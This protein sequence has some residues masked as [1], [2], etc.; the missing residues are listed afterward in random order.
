MTIHTPIPEVVPKPATLDDLMKFEG[1]AE[2]ISGRI[3]PLSPTGHLPSIVAGNLFLSLKQYVRRLG[4]GFVYQDGMGFAI[5]PLASGRR[6]FSPDAS[7][8]SGPA[9]TKRMGFVEGPPDFAAE[10]RSEDGYGQDAEIE[11]ARKRADYFE[12]STLV[13]WDVDTLVG[14]VR[15]YRSSAPEQPMV[16]R[17]G[18][19]AE[20]EPA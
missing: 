20:A 16:Y 8:Y 7:Y 12:A 11:A 3:V 17:A 14:I 6:S 4:R 5:G 2:L 13:V 19:E 9:P 1:K 10:V 15:V 18:E